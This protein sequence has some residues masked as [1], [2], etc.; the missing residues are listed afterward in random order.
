VSRK[1]E[2]VNGD[3]LFSSQLPV[4]N[5]GQGLRPE[6]ASFEAVFLCWHSQRNWKMLRNESKWKTNVRDRATEQ[7]TGGTQLPMWDVPCWMLVV[8]WR[9]AT[10][11][12]VLRPPNERIVFD[13]YLPVSRSGPE[14]PK[15]S[16][17]SVPDAGDGEGATAETS[18]RAGAQWRTCRKVWRKYGHIHRVSSQHDIRY[19][20]L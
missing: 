12:C 4:G 9:C 17:E 1:I 2:A 3:H 5:W 13:K 14:P 6:K 11:M 18:M 15:E 20:I 19:L 7:Q 10:V 16:E 8:R